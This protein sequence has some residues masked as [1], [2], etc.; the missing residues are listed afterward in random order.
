[1]NSEKAKSFIGDMLT[2]SQAIVT[3]IEGA[4]TTGEL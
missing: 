4:E 2:L 3:T 1:M